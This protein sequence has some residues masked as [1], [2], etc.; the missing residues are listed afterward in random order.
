MDYKKLLGKKETLALP[1]FG[2][3][4][5]DAS[6][7]RFRVSDELQPGL[8]RFQIEGRKAT[9]AEPT[10]EI[11]FGDRPIVR[12]HYALG[13]LAVSGARCVKLHGLPS[14]QP[15]PLVPCRARSWYAGDVLFESTEFDTD[16]ETEARSRLL[17]RR[18]ITDLKGVH[19]SLSIAFGLALFDVVART[20]GVAYQVAE[21]TPHLRPVAEGGEPAAHE[22]VD[23][24]L[25][26]RARRVAAYRLRTEQRYAVEEQALANRPP[27]P[28]ARRTA[29]SPDE[30]AEAAL[31]RAGARML[32]SRTLDSGLLEVTF[33]YM[34]TRF[35]SVVNGDTLRVV[36]AGFCLDGAD[37]ETNLASLVSVIREAM[38]D[39]VLHIT[40]R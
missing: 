39:G 32:A 13:F 4:W 35:I 25:V 9:H 14:E 34:D 19:P 37:D 2:G 6:A 29:I 16:A 5:V 26:E 27:E 18:G 33:Q 8:Y 12:G 40:R 7:R 10:S 24:L 38:Q 15:E 1:Y 20:R 22:A 30:R 21:A 3:R 23:A 31:E 11:D 17:D 28:G 36:D